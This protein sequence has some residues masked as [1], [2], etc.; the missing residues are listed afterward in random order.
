MRQLKNHGK[1]RQENTSKRRVQS[2]PSN[3]GLRREN[4]PPPPASNKS[5]P[6]KRPL[7]KMLKHRSMNTEVRT[8]KMNDSSFKSTTASLSENET[9][10]ETEMFMIDLPANYYYQNRLPDKKPPYLMNVQNR[11]KV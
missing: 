1:S 5:T 3:R 6:S 9:D 7:S 10:L 8:Y 4:N 2:K 11:V